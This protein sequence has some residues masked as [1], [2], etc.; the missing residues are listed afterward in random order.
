[1]A[2]LDDGRQSMADVKAVNDIVDRIRPILAGHS[3]G[4][5]GAVLADLLATF[6]SGFEGKDQ[7]EF[8]DSVLTAHIMTVRSLV[9]AHDEIKK[10]HR[11]GG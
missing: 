9:H 10:K 2:R 11:A 8:R 3:P 7:E 5:Q 1:L 4:T 6:L